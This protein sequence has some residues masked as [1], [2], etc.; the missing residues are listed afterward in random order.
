[1]LVA[2]KRSYM[3]IAHCSSFLEKKETH[4]LFRLQKIGCN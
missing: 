2:I 3:I 4:D 1:M